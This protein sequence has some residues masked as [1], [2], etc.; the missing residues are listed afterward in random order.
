MCY[1]MREVIIRI[2]KLSPSPEM[3]V[4]GYTKYSIL[5]M[6]LKKK[7]ERENFLQLPKE[8]GRINVFVSKRLRTSEI[9]L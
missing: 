4:K 6:I 3:A 9:G 2:E 1:C 8:V 7:K 5:S